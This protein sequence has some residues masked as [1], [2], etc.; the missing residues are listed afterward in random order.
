MLLLLLLLRPV[1]LLLLLLRCAAAASV[2]LLLLLRCAAAASVVLLLLLLLLPVR[3]LL[4]LL[5]RRAAAP[6]A[7]RQ[8]DLCTAASA[9]LLV[10]VC[11]CGS[12]AHTMSALMPRPCVLALLLLSALSASVGQLVYYATVRD[13]LSGPCMRLSAWQQAWNTTVQMGIK[14][15]A[16]DN[17]TLVSLVGTPG[18]GA[19]DSLVVGVPNVFGQTALNTGQQAQWPATCSS[20][21]SCLVTQAVRPETFC[22][23][24]ADIK[25][26]R[27]S[28]H[29][30]FDAP[31]SNPAAIRPAVNAPI[32]TPVTANNQTLRVQSGLYTAKFW[33]AEPEARGGQFAADGRFTMSRQK[34]FGAW[35]VDN[36]VYNKR[37]G[38]ALRLA[39]V[40]NNTFQHSAKTT[41]LDPLKPVGQAPAFVPLNR[42]L[43]TQQ[44]YPDFRDAP[45]WPSQVAELRGINESA[46]SA[47]KLDTNYGFTSEVHSFFEYRGGEQ[48]TFD[49]DDDV[50]VYINN[51]LAVDLGGLHSSLSSTI[52]LDAMRAQLNLTK[53]SIFHFDMYHAERH[54]RESNFR[55]TTSLAQGCN[56]QQS[57]TA[58]LR[59]GS[60]ASP[61]SASSLFKLGTESALVDGELHL[62]RRAANPH[63]GTSA[64][65]LRQVNAGTG[66]KIAFEFDANEGRREQYQG[67]ALVLHNREEGLVNLPVFSAPAAHNVQDLRNAMAV[68]LDLCA[69]RDSAPG[70]C[71]KQSVRLHYG[72]AGALLNASDATRV[73]WDDVYT[74]LAGRVPTAPN[75]THVVRVEYLQRPDWLEVYIDDS[76]YLRKEGFSPQQVLGSRSAYL[77]FTATTGADPAPLRLLSLSVDDV[78]LSAVNS[79]LL[80]GASPPRL[81]ADS[82]SAAEVLLATADFCGNAIQF[83]GFA[84][85]VQGVFVEALPD[86]DNSGSNS[87]NTN[88]NSTGRLLQQQSNRTYPGGRLEPRVVP[89]AV[90]DKGDGTYG[91][92]LR[93]NVPGAYDL[94]VC[95]GA[96]SLALELVAL[97][98]ATSAAQGV[99]VARVAP[100]SNASA[101]VFFARAPNA[102]VADPA[103]LAP[104]FMPTIAMTAPPGDDGKVLMYTGVGGGIG[105]AVL[106]I[107]A[108]L[109]VRYRRR[110]RSD[111]GFIADGAVY[112]ADKS[113]GTYSKQDAYTT[114]G[115][116]LI[117]T[118][119]TVLRERAQA[120]PASREREVNMLKSQNDE[121]AEHVRVAK[122]QSQVAAA[123][124]ASPMAKLSKARKQ[125]AEQ[126]RSSL[127]KQDDND[128]AHHL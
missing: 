1:R 78:Q 5:L 97:D 82:T 119:S 123:N 43:V 9:L 30:D 27:V 121:L 103:T 50:W 31:L 120:A 87:N 74:P 128:D 55:L 18:L 101:A 114:M 54:F 28:G 70:Q 45:V 90:V 81:V 39:A 88:N 42:F 41:S 52:S 64:Y 17:S 33:S 107:A 93:T 75:R 25:A 127:R 24:F 15:A 122:M 89:A 22:P 60:A 51:V 63:S 32:F 71:R 105:A 46:P 34:Y 106:L 125:F 124:R 68:V 76:L 118:Q 23:Y 115:R 112:N 10:A 117:E 49:G 83:G 59:L 80:L 40:G 84:S 108:L 94:Y 102:L 29:P 109:L 95:A 57:G 11:G 16:L 79:S 8:D 48:F 26:G 6:R 96:C 12:A 13:F 73:V 21:S 72:G 44:Q 19:A 67:L 113:I 2:V 110:W 58:A 3:L 99:R 98:N 56:V 7:R 14:D 61:G 69:D 116:Q 111:K 4:L 37:V 65:A 126:V 36:P 35:Y 85:L 91:V 100:S 47:F 92:T 77:G 104:T 66:F 20:A 86:G 62:I 53:G 38:V